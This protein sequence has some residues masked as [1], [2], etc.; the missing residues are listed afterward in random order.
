[1]VE[2][3]PQEHMVERQPQE[4]MVDTIVKDEDLIT[5]ILQVARSITVSLLLHL[6]RFLREGR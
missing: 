6:N 3:Q 1:M 2:R 4:R 5:G